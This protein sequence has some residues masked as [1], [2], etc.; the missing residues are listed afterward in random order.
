MVHA[1]NHPIQD[2]L[3]KTELMSLWLGCALDGDLPVA[4][5][6]LYFKK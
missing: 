5:D 6:D 3:P 4:V 1:Q 2:V